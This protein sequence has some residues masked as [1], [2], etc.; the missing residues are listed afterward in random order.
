[1]TTT[2]NESILQVNV[3]TF[4]N[5]LKCSVLR[6][7]ITFKEKNTS[8]D[9]EEE[10][11][12]NKT[13]RALER[14]PAVTDAYVAHPH[15]ASDVLV[16][17]NHMPKTNRL[18]ISKIHEKDIRDFLRFVQD[19]YQRLEEH[20]QIERSFPLH[21][22]FNGQFVAMIGLYSSCA[23]F[24][25]RVPTEQ[26]DELQ[27]RSKCLFLNSDALSALK[28]LYEDLGV[29]T[30]EDVTKFYTDYV[31]KHF[32]LFT[33]ESQMKHLI[34]LRDKVYVPSFSQGAS[35]KKVIFLKTMT[36]TAC[37]PDEEGCLHKA[38]EFFDQD[39]SVLK[40]MYEG[41]SKKFPPHHSK[42]IAG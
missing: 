35:I 9:I 30:S 27:E 6:K 22:A 5:N 36:Q 37:I 4:L 15:D 29:K 32:R 13:G 33:R 17:L 25:S 24:P 8:P 41:D 28:K 14:K 20:K 16:V 31:F 2:G 1:M 3:R 26:I 38:S 12:T 7:V 42:R 40:L 11:A 18:D 19:D 34:Y 39:N 10:T 21:K 23:F